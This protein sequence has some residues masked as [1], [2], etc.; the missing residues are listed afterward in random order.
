MNKIKQVFLS[1]LGIKPIQNINSF[2]IEVSEKDIEEGLP[3]INDSCPIALAMKRKSLNEVLVTRE[4]LLFTY[5][6]RNYTIF[7]NSKTIEFISEFDKY[8]K[9]KPFSFTIDL[10]EGVVI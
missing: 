3:G 2:Q 7:G 5:K 9:G 4:I 10:K 1:L 6:K 8:S